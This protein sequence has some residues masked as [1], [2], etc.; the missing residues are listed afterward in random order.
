MLEE[1]PVVQD[2]L[3]P[4]YLH[5]V[6]HGLPLVETQRL[7]D[8][9]QSSKSDRLFTEWPERAQMEVWRIMLD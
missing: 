8:R 7:L 1:R 4:F 6:F 3:L 9:R 2:V 5:N